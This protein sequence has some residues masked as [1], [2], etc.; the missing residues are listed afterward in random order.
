ML[1]T[2]QWRTSEG[3]A[4]G[5]KMAAWDLSKGVGSSSLGGSVAEWWTQA[6]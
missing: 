2:W 5:C 4:E 1:M 3:E 6:Q